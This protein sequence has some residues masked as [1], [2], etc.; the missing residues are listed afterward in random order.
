MLTM[1]LPP[2]DLRDDSEHGALLWH[3]EQLRV[4]RPFAWHQRVPGVTR[5]HLGGSWPVYIIFLYYS[6]TLSLFTFEFFVLNFSCYLL[7]AD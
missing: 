6:A 4:L 7:G 5:G 3:P 1:P 2:A